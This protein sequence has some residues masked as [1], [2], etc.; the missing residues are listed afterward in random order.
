[1]S[2]PHLSFV[3]F[4]SLLP[5]LDYFSLL[6]HGWQGHSLTILTV[7]LQLQDFSCTPTLYRLTEVPVSELL[8]EKE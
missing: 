2:L 6:T 5:S 4:V 8:K 1:M 3:V 7:S